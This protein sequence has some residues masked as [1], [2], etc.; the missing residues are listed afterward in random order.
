M[1]T[2]FVILLLT[3]MGPIMMA[4]GI[5][6]IRKQHWRESI[7]LAELL[8]DRAAGIDPPPRNRWDQGFA[9]VQAWLNTILGAF[10][11]LCLVAAI[12][13]IILE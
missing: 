9:R 3:A 2:I 4:L 11:T 5:A 7:P 12:V 10:F 1:K 6:S 13:S 8:I